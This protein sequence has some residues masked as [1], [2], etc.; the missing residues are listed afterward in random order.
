MT[1][2]IVRTGFASV[3]R[4][5]S[6]ENQ[7]KPCIL[8]GVLIN[9]T[10]GLHAETDGDVIYEA[11]CRAIASVSGLDIDALTEDLLMK[12]GITD[13]GSFVYAAVES[14][15]QQTISHIVISLDIK[16]PELSDSDKIA[17]RQSIA[18]IVSLP[19][20]EV[21]LTIMHTDGLTDCSCGAGVQATICLT[22]IERQ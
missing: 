16:F 13:S 15:R 3:L 18:N 4:R 5:I 17:I 6:P 1:N 19:L 2:P 9:N 12:E 10:Q 20:H 8:G 7:P 21:S 14:L 22:T 11:L